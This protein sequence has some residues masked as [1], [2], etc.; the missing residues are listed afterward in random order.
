[1]EGYA[2]AGHGYRTQGVGLT[3]ERWTLRHRAGTKEDRGWKMEDG[4]VVGADGLAVV[5][6]AGL[7]R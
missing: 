6:G 3:G 1:M 5:I 2:Q 4:E 7:W